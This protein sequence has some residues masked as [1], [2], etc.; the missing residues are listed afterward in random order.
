[1][2]RCGVTDVF[3]FVCDVCMVRRRVASGLFMCMIGAVC[4]T[5]GFKNDE[6]SKCTSSWMAMKRNKET[7]SG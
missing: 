5:E 2:V 6:L 3:G 1:M 4:G 7:G